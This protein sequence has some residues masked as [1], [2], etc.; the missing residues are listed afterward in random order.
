[1][2]LL[3]DENFHACRSAGGV[4]DGERRVARTV[5]LP[6]RLAAAADLDERLTVG[7]PAEGRAAAL[8]L[9]HERRGIG[10]GSAELDA[11]AVWREDDARGRLRDGSRCR[12]KL[13]GLG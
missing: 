6:C 8:Q 11:S 3:F 12:C 7:E 5:G 9:Q 2:P 4:Y 1:M 10:G 13:A